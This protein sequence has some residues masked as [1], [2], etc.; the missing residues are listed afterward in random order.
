MH[1]LYRK[2]YIAFLV[3]ASTASDFNYKYSLLYGGVAIEV[4]NILIYIEVLVKLIGLGC[5][6][7]IIT[8]YIL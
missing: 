3:Y 7:C 2:K 8:Y 4:Q 5:F 1:Y 6:H